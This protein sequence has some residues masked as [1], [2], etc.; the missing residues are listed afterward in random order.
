VVFAYVNCFGIVASMGSPYIIGLLKDRTGSY[1]AGL[2]FLAGMALL[3]AVFVFLASCLM[4]RKGLIA[5]ATARM[6]GL[7]QPVN[8]VTR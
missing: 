1:D 4:R 8:P 3:G 6:G 7:D 5:P 2:L